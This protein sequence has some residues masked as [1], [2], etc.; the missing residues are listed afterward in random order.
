MR[1]ASSL[2]PGRREEVGEHGPVG[3]REVGLLGQL[4]PPRLEGR[5]AADVEQP[6]RDLP[7]ARAD[8]MPVLLDQQHP[9]VVVEREHRDRS[10]V[11][12]VLAHDRASP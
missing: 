5:F 6:G 3:C 4:A 2:P 8:G 1:I 11:L 9:I 10:G 7:V 12:D